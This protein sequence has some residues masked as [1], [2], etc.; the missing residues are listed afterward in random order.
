MTSSL[1]TRSTTLKTHGRFCIFKFW[2]EKG[3]AGDTDKALFFL[4]YISETRDISQETLEKA[5]KEGQIYGGDI[6]PT[7][8]QRL[9]DEGRQEGVKIGEERGIKRERFEMALR[10]LMEDMPA[11][12][13]SIM[14]ILFN[15]SCY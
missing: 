6:L 9:R 4:T 3:F 12:R 14:H 1:P 7:L 2:Q 15:P 8:A 13:Y 11:N 10:L 5:L